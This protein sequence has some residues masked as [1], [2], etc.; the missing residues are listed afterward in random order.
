[1]EVKAQ[2][3]RIEAFLSSDQLTSCALGLR[4]L[5]PNSVVA[6]ML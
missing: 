3:G 2:V 6:A 1:M 5:I 4:Y